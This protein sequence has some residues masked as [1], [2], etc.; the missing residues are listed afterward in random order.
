MNDQTNAIAIDDGVISLEGKSYMKDARGALVPVELIKP[1]HKLEDETVRKIM[2]F[3]FQLNG[4]ISR[5][6]GHTITDLGVF[7]TLLAQ[8]YQV[9]SRGK[10]GN[11][12]YTTF[13]GLMKVVVQVQDTIEFGPT[14]QQAKVLIDECLNEWAADARPEIRAIVT[15]AFNT[16]KEGKINR[17]DIFMLLRLDIDDSRWN[18][19]MRAIR[20]AMRVAS[21]KEYIRFYSRD[22]TEDAWEP[23]TLDMARA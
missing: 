4:Q 20:D 18:E 16:D 13:D 23:V 17:S 22:K 6:R 12:T 5:F 1:Q 9:K 21:S 10:K 14:I 19:A 3:A 15:R 8:E 11:R 2:N 7:D